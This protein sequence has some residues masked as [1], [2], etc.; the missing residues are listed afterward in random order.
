MAK[1]RHIRR[2][3]EPARESPI[4]RPWTRQLTIVAF[5]HL[6]WDFVYQRPQHLLSRA[7]Q[8]HRVLYVEEPNRHAPV[9][10]M[11]LR[12]DASRVTIT[13]PHLSASSTVNS[14]RILLDQL[15]AAA[16]TENMVLWYYT[17]MALSFS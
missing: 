12:N 14:L 5:S 13:V 15:L 9:P 17:P 11:E 1:S 2:E 6:R 16:N 10:F 3:Q 8:L 4:A 7:A